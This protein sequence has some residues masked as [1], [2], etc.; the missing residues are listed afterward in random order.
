MIDAAVNGYGIAYVPENI[1]E[2][3]ISSGLL[4]QV[5][6]RL[7]ALIRWLFLLLS[8]SPSEPSSL[9]CDRRG[10]STPELK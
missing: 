9:Q 6:G 10:A 2:R 8:E 4:K 7:V 1:V 3:H 5:P